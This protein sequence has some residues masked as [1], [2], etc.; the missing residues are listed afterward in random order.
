MK[1]LVKSM[2]LA[3]LSRAE[4]ENKFLQLSMEV[5]SLS[6][7]LSWYEEQ[8]RLSRTK[9]FGP[10]SEQTPFDQ[11]SFFNE[12][13][14]EAS[15][16]VVPE[17]TLEEA[18]IL[19]RKSKGRKKAITE[20][21]PCIKI[22][23]QLSQEDRSCPQCGNFLHEM[24]K[25]IH[26]ELTIIPAQVNVT[27]K[28]RYIYACR[29]CERTGIST[30][31]IKAPMPSPVIKNSLASPSLLAH[32]MQRKYVDAVP[33]YRQEAQFG[34]Y[35]LKI[36]RQTMANWVIQGSHNWLKPLY[37]QMHQVLLTR[38]L[39]HADETV[40]EVLKEPGRDTTM[41]SYMWV[42]GTG[43]DDIPITLYQYTQGRSGDFA[44]R[45]LQGFSGYLQTDGYAGYHKL[46]SEGSPK[47]LLSGCW[48]HARRKYDEA[49]KGISEK[50]GTSA[51]LTKQGLEYCNTLFRIEKSIKH[52][53]IEERY[54]RRKQDALPTV[55]AYFNWCKDLSEKVLPKSLLGAAITYS[56]S[57]EK[58]LRR[59]LLDGG[60]EISNNRAERAIKPFVIGRKNWLFS[61]TPKG[62]E[63]SAIIYS[64]V[65]TAKQNDLN[66]FSYLEYLFHQLP[67]IDIHS[68]QVLASF[69]PWSDRLPQSCRNMSRQ[70]ASTD[71]N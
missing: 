56:L 70:L 31:I 3:S 18:K 26:R 33:L 21:L 55:E 42:Y 24:K 39:L 2:D 68:N 64:I 29:N 62:A 6:A 65:E 34:N 25:E 41:N 50:E 44:K 52:L 5:E 28:V 17:P 67:N 7:K 10:S 22:E 59:Y 60:I 54:L 19:S 30:P 20:N 38:N 69:L 53:S 32:I 36:S 14:S 63:A 57:Q 43:R 47:I 8:Y 11:L 13:E 16:F 66:P 35:G 27:E 46:E 15:T 71:A 23:Y 48:A 58:Y 4:L 12:A 1:N 9:R 45:F 40:L 51:L 49:L 37:Q 61:N